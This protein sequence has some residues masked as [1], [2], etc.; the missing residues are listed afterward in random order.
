[1]LAFFAGK[2]VDS[3]R[4]EERRDSA[5]EAVHGRTDVVSSSTRLGCS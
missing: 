1:M 3:P 5:P 4:K 2:S